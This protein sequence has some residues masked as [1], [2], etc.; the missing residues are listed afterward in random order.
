MAETQIAPEEILMTTAAE[1]AR[2]KPSG[3]NFR[4]AIS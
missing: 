2:R 4:N 3:R 1:I